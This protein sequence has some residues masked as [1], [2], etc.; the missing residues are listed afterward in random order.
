MK[1]RTIFLG[2]NEL[3]FD[4]IK[5]YVAQGNL[6]NFKK[7]LEKFNIE[8]QIINHGVNW[9]THLKKNK[10]QNTRLNE[11]LHK[12]YQNPTALSLI[13]KM[14]KKLADDDVKFNLAVSLHS[15][16]D[17]VRS[18][19]MPFSKAFPLKDLKEFTK[20]IRLQSL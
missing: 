13:S 16:I 15:A 4:Y 17:E 1:N 11:E 12:N 2:L 9:K 8:S 5:F 3:N 14:I 19:I 18:E 6:D 20:Y 7:L 10:E